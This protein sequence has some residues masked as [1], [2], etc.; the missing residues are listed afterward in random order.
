MPNAAK[1]EI[2]G[3]QLKVMQKNVAKKAMTKAIVELKNRVK[4]FDIGK[5]LLSKKNDYV[6]QR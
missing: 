2:E 4:C 5:G 6:L 1:L 3:L